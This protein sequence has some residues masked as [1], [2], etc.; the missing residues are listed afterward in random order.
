MEERRRREGLF[1][2]VNAELPLKAREPLLVHRLLPCFGLT[3]T[4]MTHSQRSVAR[5]KLR[6]YEL[7]TSP[8]C[9]SQYTKSSL[10]LRK[11]REALRPG[12]TTKSVGRLNRRKSGTIGKSPWE[13]LTV[14]NSYREATHLLTPT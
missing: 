12:L 11:Q 6:G 7:L 5:P 9:Q 10:P 13:V 14:L 4:K 1:T 3:R 2:L 8:L